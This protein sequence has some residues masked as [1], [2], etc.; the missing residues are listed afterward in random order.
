TN[1]AEVKQQKVFQFLGE[2]SNN[3]FDIAF[4]DPPYKFYKH[5][6]QKLKDL[7]ARIKTVIIDGGAIILKYPSVI[8]LPELE[9]LVLADTRTFGT[10]SV[11]IWVKMKKGSQNDANNQ[12]QLL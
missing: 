7:L 4:A 5:G 6:T 11:A 12:H 2:Q 1:K 10:S 8:K 3:S 9:D